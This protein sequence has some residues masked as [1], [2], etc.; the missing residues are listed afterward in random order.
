MFTNAFF[1]DVGDV[2]KTW[3]QLLHFVVAERDVICN[4]ALVTGLGK[5]FL[6][7]IFGL[8]IF[9]LLVKDAALCN[10]GFGGVWRH[11]GDK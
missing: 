1:N 8:L 10:S 2:F 3:R 7:L 4:I 11:L 5:C 6:E 9:F